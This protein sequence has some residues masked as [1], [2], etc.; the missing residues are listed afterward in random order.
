[1]VVQFRNWFTIL[2]FLICAAQFRN[3]VNLQIARNIYKLTLSTQFDCLGLG[4]LGS[5]CLV[6]SWFFVLVLHPLSWFCIGL[7]WFI[8]YRLVPR[9]SVTWFCCS[10][11]IIVVVVVNKH[12]HE[13]SRLNYRIGA[14]THTF[15]SKCFEWLLAYLHH[16][17][18]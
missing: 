7:F 2:Q 11:I 8:C 15:G 16:F 6:L 12:C 10:T 13:L 1:M 5:D 3:C 14:Q 18:L 4:C 17:S 9:R